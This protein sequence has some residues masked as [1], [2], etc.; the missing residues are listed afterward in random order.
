MVSF[1]EYADQ[2]DEHHCEWIAGV[3]EIL[4]PLSEAQT[5]LR[6]MLLD[7]LGDF[8]EGNGMGLLI[9]APFAVRMPEE[10]QQAR[11]PD[12]VY[13][14]NQYPE[15]VQSNYVNSHGVGLVI[16]ITDQRTRQQ[17]YG[18]KLADYEMAGIPEYWVIDVDRKQADFYQ[19]HDMTYQPASLDAS[20]YTSPV[21][22]DYALSVASLFP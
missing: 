8:I 20:V 12:L 11:E 17:D 1:I 7:T 3:I 22:R 15:T 5:R 6:D 14:S 13:V 18:Q 10:M 2:S 4:P 19:L 16:E 21:L 9:A